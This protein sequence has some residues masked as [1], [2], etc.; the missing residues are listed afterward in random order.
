V[1]YLTPQDIPEDDDCRPLFIPASSEWLAFFGGALTELTKTWNW[2]AFGAV[3]VED[4]VDKM[5]EIINTWYTESCTA[6]ETPGG[7]RIIRIGNDGQLEQLNDDG[8]WEPAT[9]E[10]YIPPPE[11][12]EEGTEEEQIC[13]AAKNAV[14]SLETLYTSLSDSFSSELTAAQALVD[15]AAIAVSFIGFEFAPITFGIA[16]L[17]FAAFEFLYTALSYLTADL[18][19]DDFSRQ[20]E[21]FLINCASNDAGVVTF[22]WDCFNN[23]L[24]SLAND[25]G[26]TETQ[27]RLY[28]Q[29][30]YM[31]QFI[32]GA[33]GLNLAGAT[34]E[35][36]SG[37]CVCGCEVQL[38]I[39]PDLEG[40]YGTLEFL[41]GRT[42][43][44]TATLF[45]GA[46]RLLIE[47]DTDLFPDECWHYL[48]DVF[49]GSSTYEEW[50]ECDCT[51]V[52]FG[53]PGA[54]HN[55]CRIYL[56]NEAPSPFTWTFDAYCQ[57]D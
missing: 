12:R 26:L 46:Y 36:E 17:A 34:T 53:M 2:E 35:I 49:S 31:L 18:W 24:A 30:A 42:W 48:D 28:L 25:Y 57:D 29:V 13:L 55:M 8:E 4:T 14:N 32:G 45:E 52:G 33:A 43:R 50:R 38:R 3:S 39:P 37:T 9:D 22:D 23:Q 47:V 7:Y 54:G 41:G 51:S 10:Y 6:C 21:C 27:I 11:A 19:D 1:P 20:I 16:A 5:A 56:A 44:G 15:F 40:E